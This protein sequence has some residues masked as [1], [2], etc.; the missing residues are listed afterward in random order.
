MLEPK[1]WNRQGAKVAR[2]SSRPYTKNKTFYFDVL[3]S[4]APSRFDDY[5][6]FF[7]GLRQSLANYVAYLFSPW[8]KAFLG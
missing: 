7:T 1:P 2:K 6:F 8:N 5:L 3:A 4:L